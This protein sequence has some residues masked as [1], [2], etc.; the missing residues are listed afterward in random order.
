MFT[1]TSIMIYMGI[2]IKVVSY[3]KDLKPG[4]K[5]NNQLFLGRRADNKINNKTRIQFI[6]IFIGLTL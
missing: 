3:K 4:Y 6:T 5:H 1:D 2:I